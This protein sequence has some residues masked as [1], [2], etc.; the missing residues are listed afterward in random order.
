MDDDNLM[1]E[2]LNAAIALSL[3]GE[4]D[5]ARDYAVMEQQDSMQEQDSMQLAGSP[6]IAS[7]MSA[8]SGTES[9]RCKV[10]RALLRTEDARSVLIP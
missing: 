8:P 6:P 5:W 10:S 9:N 7:F 3:E 4:S 2:D 1:Q